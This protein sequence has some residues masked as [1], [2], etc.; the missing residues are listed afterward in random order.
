MV[1]FHF[2]DLEFGKSGC[3]Q[4]ELKLQHTPFLCVNCPGNSV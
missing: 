4:R 1:Y 2:F 3:Q